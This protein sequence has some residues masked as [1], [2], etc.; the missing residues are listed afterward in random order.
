MRHLLCYAIIFALIPCLSCAQIHPS[1]IITGIKIGESRELRNIL[2]ESTT[3]KRNGEREFGEND[4]A[5][6]RVK[7]NVDNPAAHS[8]DEALQQTTSLPGT[9]GASLV[10]LTFEGNGQ[11]DNAA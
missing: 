4:I 3:G 8:S 9:S 2:P 7:R 10:D 5:N 11:P 6:K 1:S